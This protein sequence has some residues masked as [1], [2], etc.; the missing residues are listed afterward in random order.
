[1][2][3]VALVVAVA[4]LLVAISARGRAAKAEAR[5]DEAG[6]AAGRRVETAVEEVERRLGSERRL[7]AKVASGAKLTQEQILEGRLWRDAST[8]EALALV[9]SGA[10]V[11]DVRTPQ[12]TAG[13]VIPG[14]I[15]IP[16]Q[17][18]EA[19]A[20]ELSKEARTT[21]VYCAGGS[22]SAAAC[23]MLSSLGHDDLVNLADGFQS[24]SGPREKP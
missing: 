6:A 3:I 9:R 20:R 4:A 1:M 11:L 14:A 17:E 2:E 13:G 18:L 16:V 8:A 23:E 12:E 19:R 10:R 21:L 15:L 22:R 24:W 5:I 7:L